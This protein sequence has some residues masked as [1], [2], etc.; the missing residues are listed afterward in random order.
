ML[1]KSQLICII[2]D[3][4]STYINYVHILYDCQSENNIKKKLM[5]IEAIFYRVFIKL[6]N[7]DAS[8]RNTGNSTF[9]ITTQ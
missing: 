2:R 6:K 9:A 5:K 3:Y 7:S 1:Y 8:R 4:L